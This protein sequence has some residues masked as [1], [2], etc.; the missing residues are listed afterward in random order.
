[1]LIDVAQH[2]HDNPSIEGYN[3][4][5][6]LGTLQRLGEIEARNANAGHDCMHEAWLC[7]VH[8]AASNKRYEAVDFLRENFISDEMIEN[9]IETVGG[10]DNLNGLDEWGR[11]AYYNEGRRV[12]AYRQLAYSATTNSLAERGIS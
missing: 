11:K 4:L 8:I 3:P 6:V 2:Y 10:V 9:A 7:E 12:Q 1:M 5:V